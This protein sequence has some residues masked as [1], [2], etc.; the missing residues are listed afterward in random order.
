MS[1]LSSQTST[2]SARASARV[3]VVVWVKVVLPAGS[4]AGKLSHQPSTLRTQETKVRQ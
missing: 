1:L 2:A 3:K 4:A